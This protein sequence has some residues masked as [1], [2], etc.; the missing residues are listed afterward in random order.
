MVSANFPSRPFALRENVWLIRQEVD[1]NRSLVGWQLWIDKLS[2]SPTYSFD[3]QAHRWMKLNGGYV[4]ESYGNGYDFRNGNNFLLASGETWIGHDADGAKWFSIEAAANFDQLGGTSLASGIQLPTIPRAS[5]PSVNG[6]STFDADATVTINTNRASSSF[7]HTVQW[8]FGTQSGTI[9]SSV[10]DS[11]TW[12]PGLSLLSQIPNSESGYGTLRLITYSGSTEIGVRDIT[13]WLR[14][15]ASIVPTIGSLTVTEAVSSLAADPNLPYVQGQSKLK[16]TIGSAAGRYGS[17]IKDYS[18]KFGSQTASGSSGTTATLTSSG[19]V[20]VTATVTDSRGRT[21]S[22][23]TTITVAAWTPPN[24]T[25][26]SVVRATSGGTAS[27]SGTYFA[28]RVSARVNSIITSSTE[29]NSRT[30][31]V[32]TRTRG[33]T[34]WTLQW[35][36]TSSS[37]TSTITRTLGTFSESL[38]WDVRVD[39]VDIFK[40]STGLTSV[41]V[42]A[43][44]LDIG[45]A[46]LGVG[47]FWERGGLDVG[48][49]V[50][51]TRG[52]NG[53]AVLLNDRGTAS[54]RNAIYGVPA[55]AAERQA[56][57][58]A[59]VLWF[60]VTEGWWETYLEV[61]SNTASSVP[62]LKTG[63]AGWYP[64]GSG[65]GPWIS[66]VPNTQFAA[67]ASAWVR[68]WS[69]SL[70]KR[71]GGD[72]WFGYD[73]TN[74]LLICKRAGY[75]NL[76]A[77]TTQQTGSGTANY[78]LYVHDADGIQR[79][80]QDGN[81]FT[82]NGSLYT[83]AHAEMQNMLLSEGDRLGL[84]CHSGTLTV[85][86]GSMTKGQLTA[87]YVAPPV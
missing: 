77:W 6:G 65:D 26:L 44:G 72:A 76:S 13:F 78:H 35:S 63:S 38:G 1:N 52:A 9:A 86:M 11:T 81:A 33:A 36:A 50:W 15:P 39:I 23:S 2:Y 5:T 82:L 55:T 64:V 49:D 21:A 3:G 80:G 48:G 30:I 22:K 12:T 66:L 59:Q 60:N 19:S 47:K 71:K 85:H 20:T 25:G 70:N 24:I 74:G 40:T 17:T 68:G 4:H 37:L 84:F 31:K 62:G 29:R 16:W 69:S 58:N 28:L 56:L 53:T 32:Y 67:T 43:I 7:H 51:A 41:A 73:S 10:L 34:S 57:A 75:Y 46:N 18:L 42:A 79:Y 54:E 87:Q 14:A 27:P 61:N 8:F 83:R 45:P